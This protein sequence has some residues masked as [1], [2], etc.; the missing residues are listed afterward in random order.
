MQTM[1]LCFSV[2]GRKY[3]QFRELEV[4][5]FEKFELSKFQSTLT[6]IIYSLVWDR[7]HCHG[8]IEYDP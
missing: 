1:L 3:F 5:L 8:E 6:S 7:S 2:Q 4:N